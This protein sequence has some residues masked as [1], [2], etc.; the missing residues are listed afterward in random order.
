MRITKFTFD[1]IGIIAGILL[2]VGWYIG[3]ISGILAWVL[4]LMMIKLP[5]EWKI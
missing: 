3:E 4:L 2:V 1:P 5:I